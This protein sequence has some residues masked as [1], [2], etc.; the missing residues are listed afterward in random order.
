MTAIKS[1]RSGLSLPTPPQE[2]S[3][4]YQGI[5]NNAHS[6]NDSHTQKTNQDYVIATRLILQSPNGT[7]Y[8]ISVSNAGALS[9]T[10]VTL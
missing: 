7:Y 6:S 4:I 1:R 3:P 8:S 9:T 5:L 2:Y 10:S